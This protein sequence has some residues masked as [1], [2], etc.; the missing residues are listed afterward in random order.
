MPSNKERS[1]KKLAERLNGIYVNLV[2]TANNLVAQQRIFEHEIAEALG[3]LGRSELIRVFK[4]G[5]KQE[6]YEIAEA[7]GVPRPYIES[8]Y[9]N[10]VT[11]YLEYGFVRLPWEE[12]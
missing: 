11:H 4:N 7:H 2:E 12:N 10:M 6:F 1:D 9:A 5:S 8:V 3:S